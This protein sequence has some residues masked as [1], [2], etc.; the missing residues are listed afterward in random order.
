M[1]VRL[2]N[3]GTQASVSRIYLTE[4]QT[5]ICYLRS[6]ATINELAFIILLAFTI[7]PYIDF[8]WMTWEQQK[9]MVDFWLTHTSLHQLFPNFEPT[10]PK[11]ATVT[12]ERRLKSQQYLEQLNVQYRQPLIELIENN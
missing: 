12:P 11:L 4:P 5:I 8:N 6:D 7:I 2:T 1:E 3:Y 9:A 10:L